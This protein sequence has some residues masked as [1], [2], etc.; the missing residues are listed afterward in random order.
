MLLIDPFHGVSGDMLL[1][2][3]V[4][5]GLSI[6]ELKKELLGIPVLSE[7]SMETRRVKRGFFSASQMVIELP[8]EHAHRGLN[9]ITEIINEADALSERVKIRAVETFTLLAEA[10][11]KVHGFTKDEVHFHEVGALDAILDIVGFFVAVE[12]MGIDELRYTDLVL[13]SGTTTCQHGEIPLP[14]P[15]TAELLQGHRVRY[16]GKKEEL[17]TPTAAAIIA[18]AFE[19]LSPESTVI[20]DAMG[21][22]AGTREGEGLPNILRVSVGRI[23]DVSSRVS[24]LRTTIDDMNPEIY[25]FI[26]DR[27]FDQGVLEVY[28]HPVMMKKNRPGLEI[29]VITEIK[30]ELRIADFLLE[31]STTL[32]VRVSREE[33]VE[34]PRRTEMVATRLGD[35]QVKIGS[36]P[37]GKERVS[38]EFES[39]KELAEKS[40]VPIIEVFEIVRRAWED[41]SKSQ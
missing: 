22:G 24:I 12:R 13:G 10:E 15:A 38:P 23:E 2:A 41:Q 33:R 29:T 34:L 18:T 20:A 25:G 5:A 6:D 28:C 4:D 39:C 21:Y 7:V 32:G 14:A 8:H 3:L 17:I 16:S 26:M 9:K 31:Q 11:A 40:G 35:A 19:P 1:A 37:G 36:L 30:D 27:L